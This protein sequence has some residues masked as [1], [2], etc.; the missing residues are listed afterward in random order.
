MNEVQGGLK[1][2]SLAK[3]SRT[4]RL[5]S[6]ITDSCF[7]AQG[8]WTKKEDVALENYVARHG[9]SWTVISQKMGH[10]SADRT[11]DAPDAR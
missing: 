11:H 1:K 7:F 5:I 6:A 3:E 8:V 4:P 10:R 2:V 9:P